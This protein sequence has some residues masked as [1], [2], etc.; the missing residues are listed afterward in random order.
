MCNEYDQ[1]LWKAYCEMMQGLEWGVGTPVR[2]P[3]LPIPVEAEGKVKPSDL[4]GIISL[5]ADWLTAEAVRWGWPPAHGKGL[6]INVRSENR[7]DPPAAR[8]LSPFE[9]FYEF[10]DD[11]GK[12]KSKFE[13]KPAVNEPLAFAVVKRDDRFALMTTEPGPDVIGIHGRQPVIL[14]LS[15]WDRWLQDPEWPVDII[16]PSA[17]GTLSHVQLR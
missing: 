13:F 11:G 3:D 14:P 7:R 16:G 1:I 17:A 12:K 2:L 9:R 5:G 10:R 8:A 4:A 15:Q 6:V